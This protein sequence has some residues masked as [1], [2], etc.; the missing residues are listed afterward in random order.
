MLT[1]SS[2]VCAYFTKVPSSFSAGFEWRLLIMKIEMWRR[3]VFFH[4]NVIIVSFIHFFNPS[5]SKKFQ[6]L[7]IYRLEMYTSSLF[8][9]WA[10]PWATFNVYILSQIASVICQELSPYGQTPSNCI[11]ITGWNSGFY[12][13]WV[14]QPGMKWSSSFLFST[15]DVYEGLSLTLVAHLVKKL[16]AMQETPV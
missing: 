8:T 15:S 4:K 6:A 11:N 12:S 3:N 16:P 1:A 13:T 2:E 14:I 7:E 9:S 5:I 10:I